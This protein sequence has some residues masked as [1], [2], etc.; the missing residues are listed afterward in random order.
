[1]NEAANLAP[2]IY[3]VLLVARGLSRLVQQAR[4]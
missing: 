3:D 1:M 2:S 4:Y